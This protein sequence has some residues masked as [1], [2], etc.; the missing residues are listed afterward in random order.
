MKWKLRPENSSHLQSQPQSKTSPTKTSQI[1]SPSKCPRFLKIKNWENGTVYNDTLHHNSSKVNYTP[2]L[3]G[4]RFLF[5]SVPI[6]T[7]KEKLA[8]FRHL[9]TKSAILFYRLIDKRWKMIFK[10]ICLQK[11][12]QKE[13]MT[14]SSRFRRLCKHSNLIQLNRQR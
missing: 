10:N 3:R 13:K 4:E 8:L 14:R 1:G 2:G 5:V 6:K 7:N 12:K 11:I 9:V